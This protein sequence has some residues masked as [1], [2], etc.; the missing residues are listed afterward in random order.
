[1][2]QPFKPYSLNLK[3]QLVTIDH[4][5]VMGIVNVTPDSFTA[6]AVSLMSRCSLNGCRLW[7][8]RALM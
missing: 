4:P 2:M 7:W 3:G 1:M 5:W 8:P 6:A